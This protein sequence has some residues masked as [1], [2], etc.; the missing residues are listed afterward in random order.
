ML[1]ITPPVITCNTAKNGLRTQLCL[2]Y[3]GLNQS[4]S[5]NSITAE[6]K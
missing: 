6:Q 3:Q 5:L 1:H 2:T 4:K